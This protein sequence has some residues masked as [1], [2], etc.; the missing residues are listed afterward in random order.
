LEAFPTAWLVVVVVLVVGTLGFLTVE[1]V[2]RRRL[3][4][5][6]LLGLVLGVWVLWRVSREIWVRRAQH[7]DRHPN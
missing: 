5:G 3:F 1:M 4:W 2:S 6:N 7:S